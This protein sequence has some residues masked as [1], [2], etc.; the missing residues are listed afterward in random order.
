MTAIITDPFRRSIIQNLFDNVADSAQHYYV[1]I[2]KSEDWDSADTTPLPIHSPRDERNARLAFQSIKSAEDTSF[3]VPR[4][5]WNSGTIYTGYDDNVAGY[6]L[7]PYY[8]LTEDNQVYICLQ[9]SKNAEGTSSSST[10]K[11]TGTDTKPFTTA[12][13]YVWKFLYTVSAINASKYL[14]SNYFPVKLIDS[15]GGSDPVLDIQQF[16][17]QNAA[18]GGQ[19][20]S[21]KVITG[22]TGYSSVPTISILGNGGAALATATVYSGSIVKIEMNNDSSAFGSGFDYADIIISGGSP[23]T[24]ATAR[25]VISPKLGYGKD[26]RIDLKSTAI[27][28]NTKP[29][30]EEGGDFVVDND[31]RQVT[32]LKNPKIPTT[33][34]DFI[35]LTGGALK[36]L[37]FGTINLN[38]S[39]DK[40][41]AG[42]T[43]GATAFVDKFDSDTLYYHQTEETGFTQ[44]IS[45]ETVTETN[46]AGDGDSAS[47]FGPEVN[48]FSGD[49]LYI[50]NRAAVD[51]SASQTEDIKIIIQI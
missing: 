19:V 6:P 24:A 7:A 27:M 47:L 29:S 10:V 46:G 16:G 22:G 39:P 2:G 14:A 44:F 9:S 35:A 26:P 32:I 42:G 34:S 30:G 1:S 48:P 50:E 8:V 5:N 33:D 21:V 25:A 40:T 45:G 36:S 49:I 41:I 38:F 43:S 13:G 17:I 20:S 3:V 51:R 28:F 12:D 23:T 18:V 31:Y 11:P 15:A 37:Q 4:N